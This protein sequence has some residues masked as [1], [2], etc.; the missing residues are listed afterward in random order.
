[1]I[2]TLW[3]IVLP[4][5]VAFLIGLLFGWL[6]WRW[7][8]NTLALEQ[9]ERFQRENARLRGDNERLRDR[10]MDLKNT[11][12]QKAENGIEPGRK[13]LRASASRVAG[14]QKSAPPK[15][16]AKPDT[17]AEVSRY[18]ISAGE[19]R[20]LRERLQASQQRVT[21]LERAASAPA[22]VTSQAE[23]VDVLYEQIANRDRMIDTLRDSLRLQGA[24][25]DPALMAAELT[26]RERK[27]EALEKLL[28]AQLQ[29]D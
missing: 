5:A 18:N 27:I 12:R 4:L 17:P 2:W 10:L 16:P 13:P 20:E 3:D 23:S 29:R 7:R 8:R 9:S 6:L 21:A 26:A 24:E 25:S 28:A 1:M 15:P 14:T 22:P 11:A 19:V